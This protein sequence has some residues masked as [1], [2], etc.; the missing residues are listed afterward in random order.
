MLTAESNPEPLEASNVGGGDD[1]RSRLASD[2]R[3][4]ILWRTLCQSYFQKLIREDDTLLE[5]GAGYCDFSNHIKARRRLAID[6][7][8]GIMDAAGP[9][10]EAHVGELDRLDWV[11]DSSVDFAFASN[12][13]EHVPQQQFAILLA[14]LRFKLSRRGRIC[15]LQPNYRYC[16]REYFDDYTHIA[17]YSHVSLCDFLTANAY[18]VL[19]CRRRFLP[20]TIKSRLPVY[21]LLIK[22]YL[23]MPFHPFG[24]QM[25]I[26]AAP[27]G[28]EITAQG[29]S[30]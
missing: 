1:F 4:T 15:L 5:L 19:D 9:G 6:K 2:H 24:K 16:Y 12:V 10:V 3:R 17:V 26:L 25:L 27:G 7:W 22:T 30:R 13:F 29:A 20:L 8:S 18:R 23:K 21:P 11:P 28:G 14:T